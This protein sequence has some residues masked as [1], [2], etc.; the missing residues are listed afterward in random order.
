MAITGSDFSKEDK[1]LK[2]KNVMRILALCLAATVLAGTAGCGRRIIANN[3]KIG[4]PSGETEVQEVQVPEDKESSVRFGTDNVGYLVVKNCNKNL[5]EYQSD[6]W[7][8]EMTGNDN[9]TKGSSTDTLWSNACYNIKVKGD[10]TGIRR[11]LMTNVGKKN[12]VDSI[13]TNSGIIEYKHILAETIYQMKTGVIVDP[14]EYKET[15]VSEWKGMVKVED[16]DTESV[17]MKD[18]NGTYYLLY[19]SGSED[20]FDSECESILSSFTPSGRE[21]TAGLFGTSGFGKND[22]NCYRRLSDGSFGVLDV[23]KD[24][25]SLYKVNLEEAGAD[26]E[27]GMLTLASAG[28]QRIDGTF[29][30]GTYAYGVYNKN[31]YYD[32]FT[33]GKSDWEKEVQEFTTKSGK[34][35]AEIYRSDAV[36]ECIAQYE[37]VPFIVQTVATADESEKEAI[38]FLKTL[39]FEKVQDCE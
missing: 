26:T 13:F 27:D 38:D 31:I 39:V 35:T 21:Q 34:V 36:T 2:K 25:A 5:Y 10:D 28:M 16:G 19:I 9:I 22:L 11:I 32:M 1:K 18:F 33:Q 23:E 37:N 29:G 12:S 3:A 8:V 20:D 14:E 4:I 17:F 30:N 15:E 24:S 7:T 6:G